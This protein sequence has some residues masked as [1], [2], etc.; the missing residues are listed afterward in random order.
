MRLSALMMFLDIRKMKLNYQLTEEDY[1][2]FCLFAVSQ[3]LT[4]RD[5]K[6]RILF[7]LI[8]MFSLGSVWIY[9]R[10]R[11]L[12][13]ITFSVT[14]ILYC[15]FYYFYGYRSIF[16]RAYKKN[17]KRLF[18]E[19]IG[20]EFSVVSDNELI[21]ILSNQTKLEINL[22]NVDFIEEIADYYFIKLK[23]SDRIIIPKRIFENGTNSEASLRNFA[24]QNN[25]T[26]KQ[27][28]DW[29]F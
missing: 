3:N 11:P 9:F 19:K 6:R 17:V 7:L 26:I 23:T 28:L 1:L 15:I 21:T 18:K 2:Q 12:F 8:L 13:F 25:I 24:K 22:A 14:G 29:K 27:L 5:A 20:M 4:L 10:L 16:K